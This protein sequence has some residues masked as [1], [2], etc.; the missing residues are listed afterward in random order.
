MVVTGSQRQ[1]NLS[2]PSINPSEPA[3]MLYL[4]ARIASTLSFSRG[5]CWP[6]LAGFTSLRWAGSG[7]SGEPMWFI[8]CIWFCSDSAA[9][10]GKGRATS[11]TAAPRP[12]NSSCLSGKE[13]LFYRIPLLFIGETGTILSFQVCISSIESGN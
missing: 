1:G 11:P 5:Q 13:C 4:L 8:G 9:A 10:Q 2:S 6:Q 12:S 3:L 7:W